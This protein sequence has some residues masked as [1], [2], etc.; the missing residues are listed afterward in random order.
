MVWLKKAHAGSDSFGHV[1]TEDGS[2]VDVPADEAVA[3]LRIPDGGF[4]TVPDPDPALEPEP[5]PAPV[6]DPELEPAP[7]EEDQAASAPARRGRPA[8]TRNSNDDN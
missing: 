4:S 6:P 5:A 2:V 8:K 3:L 1:W 7:A